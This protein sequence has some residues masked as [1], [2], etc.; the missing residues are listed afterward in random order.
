MIPAFSAGLPGNTSATTTLSLSSLLSMTPS[1][2]CPSSFIPTLKL[3][4][5]R[6]SS[7]SWARLAGTSMGNAVSTS[8]ASPAIPTARTDCIVLN[9]VVSPCWIP[10]PRPYREAARLLWMGC[11]TSLVRL[12]RTTPGSPA[13]G[14]SCIGAATGTGVADGSPR[15]PQ[16]GMFPCFFGGF[17]SRLS[18][19]MSSALTSRGRVSRGSITS[20]T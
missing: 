8:A 1:F 18:T 15:P 17:A 11:G 16:S 9:I 19:N 14:N 5:R 13:A 2:G 7:F 6:S 20:S 10:R 4:V 12:P 3:Q